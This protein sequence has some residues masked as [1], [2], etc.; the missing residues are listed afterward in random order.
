MARPKKMTPEQAVKLL[1]IG[2]KRL[3]ARLT[4]AEKKIEKL[5]A[6]KS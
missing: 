1:L 5:S 2:M 4:K 3:E 6:K